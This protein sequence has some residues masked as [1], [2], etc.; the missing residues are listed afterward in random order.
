MDSSRART[1]VR[2]VALYGFG[3]GGVLFAAL[4]GVRLLFPVLTLRGFL[5]FTTLGC[6]VLGVAPFM[7]AGPSAIEHDPGEAGSMHPGTAD[8]VTVDATGQLRLKVCLPILA[9]GGYALAGF[10]LLGS[11]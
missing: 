3:G 6:V 8:A 9:V 1:F 11:L 2:Q 4:V 7:L 5:L 10:V